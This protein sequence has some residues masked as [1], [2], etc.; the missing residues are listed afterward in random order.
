MILEYDFTFKLHENKKPTTI[1]ETNLKVSNKVL[2]FMFYFSLETENV[3]D[4]PRSISVFTVFQFL[5]DRYETIQ[6][7][8]DQR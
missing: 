7:Q 8:F 4:R 6:K 5:M 1:N 3:L 2:S